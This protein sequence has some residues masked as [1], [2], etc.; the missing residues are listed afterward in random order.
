MRLRFVTL[1]V[2]PTGQLLVVVWTSRGDHV[3]LISARRGTAAERRQ[4][5]EQ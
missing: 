4:Y 2:D 3:R 1:G 5:E